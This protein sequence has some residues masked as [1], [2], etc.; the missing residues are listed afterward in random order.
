[1]RRLRSHLSYANVAA[2]MALVLA[3]GGGATAIALKGK[4]TVRSDDIAPQQV[5]T[6]DIKDEAVN[7]KK[8]KADAVT[9]AQVDE[10]TLEGLDAESLA[11][12]IIVSDQDGAGAFQGP[13]DTVTLGAVPGVGHVSATCLPAATSIKFVS[14]FP[15]GNLA[16]WQD[17]GGSDATY[18]ELANGGETPPATTSAADT[19]GDIVTY[20]LHRGQQSAPE[21][22]T[23]KGTLTVT[24]VRDQDTI[25]DLCNFTLQGIVEP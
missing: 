1:M 22:Q 13:G 14:A 21:I 8:I 17:Q 11:G 12:A 16:V 5:K 25:P 24:A 4:N 20:R 10:S 19:S 7:A 18:H 15:G 23:P 2:T 3:L 9:G 6:G